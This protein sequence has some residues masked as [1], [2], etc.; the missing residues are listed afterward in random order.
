MGKNYLTHCIQNVFAN[1]HW[2]TPHDGAIQAIDPKLKG[3][4]IRSYELPPNSAV[5]LPFSVNETHSSNFGWFEFVNELAKGAA[6][7]AWQAVIS[8]EE[9]GGGEVFGTFSGRDTTTDEPH[10]R[11]RRA[12]VLG[13]AQ[14]GVV[15]L[16]PGGYF[17]T[18][19]NQDGSACTAVVG[20][21]N[22]Y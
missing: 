20:H 17:Y 2:A 13:H 12:G 4:Q 16:E 3:L 15:E 19:W 18:F 10:A 8:S 1:G 21:Q 9:N 22:N 11:Y 14:K 7:E 5:S 6:G